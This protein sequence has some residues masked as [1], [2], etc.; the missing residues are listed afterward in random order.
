MN[1]TRL[2]ML[3]GRFSH[4]PYQHRNP[5][6]REDHPSGSGILVNGQLGSQLKLI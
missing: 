1:K 2:K 3:L 4:L 5:L 6:L